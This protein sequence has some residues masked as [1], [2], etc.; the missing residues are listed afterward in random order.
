MP[1][2]PLSKSSNSM[3]VAAV[4]LMAK[5]APLNGACPPGGGGGGGGGVPVGVSLIQLKFPTEPVDPAA[6]INRRRTCCPCASETPDLVTVVQ[7]C[8]PAVW[9]TVSCPVTFAP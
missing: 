4:L 7:F 6:S 2:A 9:G 5:G 8:Q 3:T 1:S